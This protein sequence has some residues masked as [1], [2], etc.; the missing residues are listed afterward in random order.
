MSFNKGESTSP[1]LS[2]IYNEYKEDERRNTYF[3]AIPHALNFI[4]EE[5]LGKSQLEEMAIWRYESN[6]SFIKM[7]KRILCDF[8]LNCERRLP[9]DPNDERMFAAESIITILNPL[10][11]H[12]K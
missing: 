3:K 11:L 1:Q 2:K 4:K 10:V 8:I 9:L 7:M 5:V 12:V 6:D